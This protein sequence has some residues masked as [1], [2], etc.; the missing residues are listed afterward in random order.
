MTDAKTLRERHGAAI[1]EAIEAFA[2]GAATGDYSRVH[3]AQAKL[4]AARAA[5]VIAPAA[6]TATSP[7]LNRAPRTLDQAPRDTGRE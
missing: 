1:T 3:A 6:P 2:W 5:L 4:A 7:F